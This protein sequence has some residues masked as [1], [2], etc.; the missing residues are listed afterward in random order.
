M[1]NSPLKSNFQTYDGADLIASTGAQPMSGA[2]RGTNVTLTS[3]AASV[4]INL[5]LSNN[6]TH[7]FTENTTLAAPT[8]AV[9][10]QSG[11]IFLK[12]HA[13]LP[14]TLTFNSFWKFPGGTPTTPV[15]ATNNANDAMAYYVEPGGTFAICQMINDIKT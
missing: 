7:T 9:A 2:K 1:A 8:N 3:T 5:A 14:K 6:Y 11:I 13:S 12:Q 4:A 10:G 15:T